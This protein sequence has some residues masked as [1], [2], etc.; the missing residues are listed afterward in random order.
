V[1]GV[2]ISGLWGSMWSKAYTGKSPDFFTQLAK[3]LF[4]TLANLIFFLPKRA[5]LLEFEDLT[6]IAKSE[7]QLGKKS[8][9]SFLEDFYNIRG[10]EPVL[11][12]KHFFYARQL[13][14]KLP[15][16]ITGSSEENKV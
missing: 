11:F 3:G 4:F 10:E 2:R 13:K 9:N 15:V 5:V 12:L 14:R 8:F 16:Q 6:S 7:A 1:I